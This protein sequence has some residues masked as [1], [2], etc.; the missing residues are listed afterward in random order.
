MDFVQWLEQ[1]WFIIGLFISFG[2]FTINQTHSFDKLIQDIKKRDEELDQKIDD[3][4][5]K[6]SDR[7]NKNIV[8]FKEDITK[9]KLKQY[10]LQL[11]QS[12]GV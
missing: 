1:N 4:F 3:S 11:V 7:M 12:V 8:A 9:I 5:N 10:H 6:V 2:G